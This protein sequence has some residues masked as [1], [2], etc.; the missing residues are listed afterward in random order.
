MKK[1]IILVGLF[2]IL[3]TSQAQKL[4]Y[5]LILGGEVYESL[6]N[7]GAYSF[8]AD[9]SL[10]PNLGAYVEYGFTKNIGFKTGVTFNTKKITYSPHINNPS[11][12][13]YPFT[14]SLIEVS[15]S[16]KFDFGKEYRN[17]FY[18][19]VGP[20]F[21]FINKVKDSSGENAND[22]F[23]RKNKGVQLGFGTRIGKFI[24]FETK[25]DYELT[26]FFKIPESDRQSNFG[27]LYISLNVDLERII[28][29][30]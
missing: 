4:S 12:T 21:S 14:L 18:M 8:T 17:G 27:G 19:L 20:K 15:P 29:K 2:L 24:D 7:T 22:F 28:D 1:G 10:I 26:P 30:S 13:T 25:F 11:R 5:G 23:E 3:A 6:N 16:I 9:Q